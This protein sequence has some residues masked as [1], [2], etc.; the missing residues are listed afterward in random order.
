MEKEEGELR[1][2]HVSKESEKRK[3]FL[4]KDAKRKRRQ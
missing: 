3:F 1:K 2:K 4:K